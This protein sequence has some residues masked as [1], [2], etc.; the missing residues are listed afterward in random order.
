MWEVSDS[1][2]RGWQHSQQSSPPTL[3][4]DASA[5][6]ICMVMSF[7]MFF[8]VSLVVHP[9]EARLKDL[10]HIVW[11][12]SKDFCASGLRFG[13]LH[14]RVRPILCNGI[15]VHLPHGC[16]TVHLPH[17]CITVH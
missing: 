5:S 11:G 10:L 7:Y 1:H 3:C 6:S 13:C 14:R 16:I 4:L 8:P 2:A 17:G 15:T 9:G 12:L